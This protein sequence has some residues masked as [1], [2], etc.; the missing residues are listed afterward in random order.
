MLAANLEA[1]LYAKRRLYELGAVIVAGTDAGITPQ[2]PHDV[3]AYAH[4]DFT[5]M[6]MTASESMRAMT[7]V[8]AGAIG[9]ATTKGKLAPGFDADVLAVHGDPIADPAALTS[10]AG[11]WR[12]G[13]AIVPPEDAV[14]R[15]PKGG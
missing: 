15:P 3:L 14:N 11:V 5:L 10:V 1:L 6:G 12:A 9:L 2:K 8:A 13:V 7:S 4:V